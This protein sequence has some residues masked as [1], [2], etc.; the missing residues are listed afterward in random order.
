MKQ[1]KQGVQ[2]LK[3]NS[4]NK[5]YQ[6]TT[7]TFKKR[8]SDLQQ[9]RRPSRNLKTKNVTSF[10]EEAIKTLRDFGEKL[11]IHS[12]SNLNKS[13]FQLSK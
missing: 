4:S 10:T 12:D 2:Y 5:E 7:K 9:H 11:K 13:E 8:E 6:D 1:L 3:N